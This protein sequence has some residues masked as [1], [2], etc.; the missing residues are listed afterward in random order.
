MGLSNDSFH[1]AYLTA[2][3]DGGVANYV[4]NLASHISARTTIIGPVDSSL[5]SRTRNLSNVEFIGLP[6]TTKPQDLRDLR[7]VPFVRKLVA[8]SGFDVLH[9]NSYKGGLISALSRPGGVKTRY[10]YSPHCSIGNYSYAVPGVTSFLYSVECWAAGR[11]DLLLGVCEAEREEFM[12]SG[13]ASQECIRVVPSSIERKSIPKRMG[14]YRSPIGLT[15]DRYPVVGTL[16]RLHP[17]KRLELLVRSVGEVSG[18]FPD[19]KLIIGGAGPSERKLK[20]LVKSQGLEERVFFSGH[21]DD[22]YGFLADL[23]V[24]VLSSLWE[25]LPFSILEAGMMKLPVVATDVGGV[26]EVIDSSTGWL[27][28]PGDKTGLSSALVECLSDR[29]EAARRA[30]NLNKRV[31]NGYMI[32][33][34]VEDI[35]SVYRELSGKNC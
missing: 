3:G 19:A 9:S 32:E 28:A 5:E 20:S 15:E 4:Y 29:S 23:D 6:L 22:C 1:I 34:N 2:C 24:F 30:V 11:H 33:N 17:Q 16:S 13:M 27:V 10:V 14:K 26:R 12:R 25:A 8:S 35:L 18:R 31:L 7:F 21:V